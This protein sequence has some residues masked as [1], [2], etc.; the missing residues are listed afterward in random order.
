M[1]GPGPK[2][3]CPLPTGS[4]H[5][6]RRRLAARRAPADERSTARADMAARVR[7]RRDEL[8]AAT[9]TTVEFDLQAGAKGLLRHIRDD[10]GYRCPST[11]RSSRAEVLYLVFE[12][13]GHAHTF[14]T[15]EEAGDSLEALDLN[16]G[17]YIGA[18]S[19]QG[20][21]I[22]MSAGDLWI[23]FN[24]SGTFD[25]TALQTLIRGCR[26]F[27]ELAE[28]PHRFDLAI[29]RPAELMAGQTSRGSRTRPPGWHLLF[30]QTAVVHL[31][32]VNGE[33]TTR[34]PDK[35][36]PRVVAGGARGACGGMRVLTSRPRHVRTSIT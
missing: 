18:F 1:A 15:L 6:A 13:G 10:D 26:T 19:D 28:D 5:D 24:S 22:T 4:G 11:R 35:P 14:E 20:E 17:H 34:Q 2:V 30:A 16:E 23:T 27:S 33:C 21:V 32:S 36:P 12:T 3:V 31:A 7:R 8:N 9:S 29:C 25:N